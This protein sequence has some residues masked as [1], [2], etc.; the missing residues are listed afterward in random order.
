MN[1]NE[2][3]YW[4]DQA[5]SYRELAQ[6]AHYPELRREYLEL[7]EACDEIAADFEARM[8]SG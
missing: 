7:A 3:D 8:P 1:V 2:T 5:T 4:W 6:E